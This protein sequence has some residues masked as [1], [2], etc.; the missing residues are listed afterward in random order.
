MEKPTSGFAEL[1][2]NKRVLSWC[3]LIFI[4]PINFGYEL[5]LVGNILA[6]P[7]F[8]NKFGVTTATGAKEI[9]THDQQILNASTTIGVFVAAYTTGFISD[10]IGRRL[11]VLLGC[12]LCIAGIMVQG[13]SNSIMMLFGGKLISTVG[14]GLGHTLGPVYVAEIAPDS[15]RG[16]CLILIN[17]MIVLGQWSCALVGYG[18]S[19]IESDWGWRLPVFTQLVPPVLV[20]VLGGL[21][22]PESP[23]W[24]LMKG[25]REEAAK[26]LRKFNGPKH[27]VEETL[28]IMETT[29]EKEK[30]LNDRGASYLEYF[31]TIAGVGNPI[32]IAQVCYSIQLL[33]NI[34]SW[35]LVERTG[36]RPL[37]VWGII[38]MS[39]LLLLIG[40]LSVIENNQ[41]ALAAVVAFMALWGFLYQL[42]IGAVAFAVG[43]ETP[44]PRLRQKTYSITIMSNT[45]AGCLVTQLIPFL[46]NPSNANL[47]GKVAF[48]FFAPSLI[49]SVYL[50]FCFPEMKGR[51]YLELE[52][53][54]Q[55]G[56]PAR[57]F[58]DYKCEVETVEGKDG[59]KVAVVLKD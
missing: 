27:N 5:A 30:E 25:R 42:S 49:C 56:V 44:S 8:L 15:L 34:C 32:G 18:G 50:F 31:F 19:F 43:G 46:I 4:L 48:V 29:L 17:T 10:I 16:V 35:F 39:A 51:S 7:S 57:K 2:K 3:L 11:V 58:K 55:K 33:G 22:L 21:L 20:L 28:A 6:I 26:A 12:G 36:R 1:S 9:S 53:M 37:I 41:Q 13:F 38:S 54:F 52:D 23:T 24:L 45:S 47:G 59:E 40:G 14:Y